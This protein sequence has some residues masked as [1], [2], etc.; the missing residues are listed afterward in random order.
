M[1]DPNDLERQVDVVV[2][3]L[4]T[5]TAILRTQPTAATV[6]DEIKGRAV[7]R[8]GRLSVDIALGQAFGIPPCQINAIQL[9]AAITA[10]RCHQGAAVGCPSRCAVG[11]LEIGHHPTLATGQFMH[12]NHRFASLERNIRQLLTIGRP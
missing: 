6:A 11:A 4:A 7:R 9:G 3:E 12:I 8:K 2:R 1:N 5:L 10:E